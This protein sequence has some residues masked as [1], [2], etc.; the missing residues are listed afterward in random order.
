VAVDLAR[1]FGDN[2]RAYR[3][4][5]GYTQEAFAAE[6]VGVSRTYWNNIERGSRNLTLVSVAAIA[7]TLDLDP[8]DLLAERLPRRIFRR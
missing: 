5:C 4:W 7:E 2:L 8:A 3:E 6:V 1:R